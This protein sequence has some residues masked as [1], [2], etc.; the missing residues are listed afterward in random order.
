[1]WGHEKLVDTGDCG[2]QVLA[3]ARQWVET[4]I[5]RYQP[6]WAA[7]EAPYVP[8]G[9]RKV[10]FNAATNSRLQRLAGVAE[11]VAFERGVSYRE[12][13]IRAVARHFLGSHGALLQRDK[14]KQLTK[15]Y[16]E[17]HGWKP[18]S[19]DEADALALLS[20]MEFSLS[21]RA[22]RLRGERLP[23]FL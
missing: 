15:T 23:L 4:L 11:S 21:P 19:Q 3:R 7:T 8:R 13:D 20:Y 2:G 12:P 5:D 6:A 18:V 10:P 22:A 17:A 16:C 9:D 1:V 14:K